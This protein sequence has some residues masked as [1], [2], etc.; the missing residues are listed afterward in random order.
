MKS[1]L[2]DA[3]WLPPA[4][5]PVHGPNTLWKSIAHAVP[6][7]AAHPFRGF[8]SLLGP[9]WAGA[10]AVEVMAATLQHP[11]R[12]AAPAAAND[13]LAADSDALPL[14]PAPHMIRG[15][16]GGGVQQARD[17]CEGA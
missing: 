14:G 6:S 11:L 16:L 5:D 17:M 4:F 3:A 1:L 8:S 10:L 7:V 2:H 13:P 9:G 15:R 12:A